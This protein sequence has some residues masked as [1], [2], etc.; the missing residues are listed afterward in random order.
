M[1]FLLSPLSAALLTTPA[2]QVER[3]S[4]KSHYSVRARRAVA[5]APQGAYGIKALKSKLLDSAAAFKAAQEVEWQEADDE[6]KSALLNAESVANIEASTKCTEL[7]A[8]TISIIEELSNFNPTGKPFEGW[9]SEQGSPLE[10]GWDLAF[11]TGADATFRKTEKSGSAT[12]YQ[13]IDSKKGLFINC[14]DFDN[15]NNKLRGFRVYVAGVKLSDSEVQLKF[16]AVKLLR[17]SSRL[18]SI[19]IPLPPARAS[20]SRR[21]RAS[22]AM[23][24]AHARPDLHSRSCSRG[25]FAASPS[26]R[27]AARPSSR[28][29]ARVSKFSIWMTRSACTRPSMDSISFRRAGR[30]AVRPRR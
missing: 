24:P 2:V 5:V 30:A 16:R 20:L 13:E 11:T 14:I 26:L 10:G 18:P 22:G 9:R 8:Q 23:Q 3:W 1:L 25:S 15:P 28:I 27:A 17:R 6:P 4:S 19:V 7:R 12:T 21:V 29:G